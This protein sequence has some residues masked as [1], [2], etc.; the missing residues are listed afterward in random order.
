MMNTFIDVS[1]VQQLKLSNGLF[2]LLHS[3]DKRVTCCNGRH[4]NI[5]LGALAI[6]STDPANPDKL[7]W[8]TFVRAYDDKFQGQIYMVQFVN[9]LRVTHTLAG[10]ITPQE[11]MDD[12]FNDTIDL[13]RGMRRLYPDFN[14]DTEVT[15]IR[16][17]VQ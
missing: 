4:H 16:F 1:S 11:A 2:P 10:N 14:D 6:L 9:V 13:I 5:K 17:T 15:F 3:G 8:D 7:E 12:G